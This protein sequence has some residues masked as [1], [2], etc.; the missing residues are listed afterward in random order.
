LRATRYNFA[1]CEASEL[2][3]RP[4][5]A[6][7]NAHYAFFCCET[8]LEDTH[9]V[10]TKAAEQNFGATMMVCADSAGHLKSDKDSAKNDP[11]HRH[12]SPTSKYCY[13]ENFFSEKHPLKFDGKEV[14][15]DD[16]NYSTRHGHRWVS[17]S[18]DS[19][20]K[21]KEPCHF[22]TLKQYS[23]LLD[24]ADFLFCIFPAD[25]FQN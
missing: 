22:V 21:Y 4:K 16:Q 20:C 14:D 5:T 17:L 18:L 23:S 6:Q 2:K 19:K 9:P 15:I 11:D 25:I 3:A 24:F 8:P 1:I 12:C 10:W 7:F 13:L